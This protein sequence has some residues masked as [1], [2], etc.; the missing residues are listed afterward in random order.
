MARQILDGEG[1]CQSKPTVVDSATVLP[2]DEE[3]AAC[4]QPFECLKGPHP[5]QVLGLEVPHSPGTK[6]DFRGVVLSVFGR[7]VFEI[8]SP[9]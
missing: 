9:L 5:A 2:H 6:Q 3:L 7:Q 4:S 8:W 1:V